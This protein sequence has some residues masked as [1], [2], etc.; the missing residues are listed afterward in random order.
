METY[1]IY[2]FTEKPSSPS[3]G[4]FDAKAVSGNTFPIPK[5]RLEKPR[6]VCQVCQLCRLA[7]YTNFC[8]QLENFVRHTNEVTSLLEMP[9]QQNMPLLPT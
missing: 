5:T 6:Q 4:D 3:K 1:G 8:L 2:I 7:V 9:I